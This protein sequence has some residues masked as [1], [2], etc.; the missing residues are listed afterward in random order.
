MREAIGQPRCDKFYAIPRRVGRGH[1]A[2]TMP[3]PWSRSRQ[4][5]RRV[6]LRLYFRQDGS[7]IR[8]TRVTYC[9]AHKGRNCRGMPPRYFLI[10]NGLYWP[11]KLYDGISAS[12]GSLFIFRF[13][14]L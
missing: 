13:S 9:M 10:R 8:P 12:N 3:A 2:L 14:C 11:K 1:Y 5:R 6:F 7:A 4:D